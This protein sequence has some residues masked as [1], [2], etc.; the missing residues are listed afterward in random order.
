MKTDCKD[1]GPQLSAYLDGELPERERQELERHLKTCLS[2]RQLVRELAEAG[3]VIKTAYSG[4]A[5]HGV[6]LGGV[7]K[8]IEKQADFGPTLWQ[9]LRALVD[10]P[11][12]WLPAAAAAAAVGLL[13]FVTPAQKTDEAS[14]PSR[15]ESVYSR[16]GQVMLLQT[17]NSR[18][19]IIWVLPKAQKEVGS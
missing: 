8:T 12:V 18:S 10:R 14:R 2:C 7:W 19:P 15:V 16:T 9:R 3:D 17:A 5:E 13:I 4:A 1:L 6:D 11:V